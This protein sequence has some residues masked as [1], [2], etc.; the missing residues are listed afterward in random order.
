MP[1]TYIVI[2]IIVLLIILFLYFVEPLLSR[3]K[4]KKDNEHGSARWSSMREIKNNFKMEYIDNIDETGFPVFFGKKNTKVWFDT[5]TPHWILL[6]SSGSGKSVTSVIPQCSFIASSKQKKSVFITDPKGE[7]F[8]HTSLMFK[9]N[10]YEVLTLDFRNPSLSNH[11]NLLETIIKEYEIYSENEV[12]SNQEQSEEKRIEYKNRSIIHL[13]E[14]NQLVGTLANMIMEDKTAKEKFWNNSSGDLLYGLIFLFLEDYING[15]IER[16]KITLPSIKKFQNSSMSETNLKTLKKYIELKEYGCK[17]KD[18]LLPL[19]N[20]SETTYRSITSTFNE[21]MSLFDDVNVENLISNSDFDFDILGK[22]PTV[23]YCCIPDESKVYYSLVSIIV[24][25]IYRSLV[26]VCNDQD[27]KKLPCELIFLLDEFSNTPPLLDIE[28]IV[29]VA[30]SRGMYFWFY[31]QS[32]SQ[33]DNL[34]G[35]EV[36]QIIQDN[37]GLAYLKTNTQETAESISKLLGSKTIEVSSLNYSIGFFNAN[38]SKNTSLM[39]R[40]LMTPDEIKQ[41]HFQ[42][43]I[44]PNIGYPILRD[45]VLYNKFSCYQSGC[46]HRQIRPLQKLTDTY[47]TVEQI[48]LTQKNNNGVNEEEKKLFVPI[49]KNV[50]NIFRNVDYEIDYSKVDNKTVANIYL[51][52]PM[53]NNDILFLNKLSLELGFTFSLVSSK[54]KVNKKNRNS[55]IEIYLERSE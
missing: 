11:R 34:Y 15:K 38:G 42:T 41:L 35:R 17:S 1:I 29:S 18:K 19:L 9:N 55:K 37:T 40:N 25:L 43:I 31:L 3:E 21:R 45:T 10:G 32:F 51:S 7:I 8:A 50:L 26:L 12:L 13:A 5:S 20:T 48:T 6:G 27:S 28:T 22:K 54:E 46:I 2:L 44:F 23:L 36:S 16:K 33:L 53:S 49:I 30:R 47:Y 39:G 4:I 24:S 14:C 52:C